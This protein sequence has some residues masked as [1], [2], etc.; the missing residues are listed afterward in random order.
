MY[1]NGSTE[2]VCEMTGAK[3]EKL[4]QLIEEQLTELK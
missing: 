1:A 4:Q 2:H 3:P